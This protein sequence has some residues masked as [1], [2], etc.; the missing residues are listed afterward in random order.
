MRD[1]HARAAAAAGTAAAA[2]RARDRRA[3]PRVPADIPVLITAGSIVV[4]G[5]TVDASEDGLGVSIAASAPELPQLVRVALRLPSRGWEEVEGEII[6]RENGPPEAAPGHAMVGIRLRGRPGAHAPSAPAPSRTRGQVPRPAGRPPSAPARSV[7]AELRAL[8]SVAYEQAFHGPDARPLPAL[9]AWANRLAAAL[10]LVGC[11]PAT[12]R[13]L[14]QMVAAL[15]RRWSAPLTRAA[16]S[17]VAG[18]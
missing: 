3:R 16:R 13:E 10:G 8:A 12:N 17:S 15:H 4:V 14:L 1:L 11:A 7:G 5:T 6:R 18:R 2:G 9:L